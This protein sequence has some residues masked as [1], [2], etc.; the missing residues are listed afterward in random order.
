MRPLLHGQGQPRMKGDILKRALLASPIGGKPAL[1]FAVTAV[2]LPSLVRALLFHL[3]SAGAF[4][5]YV[6]FVLL[7]AAILKPRYRCAP[8]SGA[9]SAMICRASRRAHPK[10]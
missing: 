1:L 3:V 2:A 7:S 6:P 10:R 5:T 9:S 8:K 4:L